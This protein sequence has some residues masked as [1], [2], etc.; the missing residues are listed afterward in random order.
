[1]N[2]SKGGAMSGFWGPAVMSY[3]SKGAVTLCGRR[4]LYHRPDPFPGKMA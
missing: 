2:V 4:E 1:V 3:I